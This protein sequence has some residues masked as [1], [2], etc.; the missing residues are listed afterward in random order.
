LWHTMFGIRFAGSVA[1]SLARSRPVNFAPVACT[2]HFAAA[3]AEDLVL[4]EK[5]GA[6]AI[7]TLNRP[8]SLNALN[9]SLVSAIIGAL[10]EVDADSSI[11][12][13]V[14]TGSGKAFAAGADIKEMGAR[15]DYASVRRDNM[16]VHWGEVANIR[17]PV[18]AAVNGFALGGGCE[19]AMACDIIIAS[20]KAKFG[21]PE[22]KLGTIP[23]CGGTQRLLRAI[24][25]SKAMEWIL[26]GDMYSAEQAE[27]AGL[28]SKVVPAEAI[29]DEA[30]KMAEKIASFSAPVQ[31][32]AKECVNAAAEVPLAEGLKY[33]KGLFHATWGLEDRR[34]GFAAFSEKREA[35]WKHR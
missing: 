29:V 23:G 24:G 19:L 9:D 34:E 28:V 20:E 31:Q 32:L 18:I 30:V 3:A 12:A 16:L 2:R 8:K 4:V 14:L 22:I 33:E 13:A 35:T 27:R 25:K 11:R 7:V 10:R 21:Q 17:M 15:V 5:K 1:R 26:T 6:V